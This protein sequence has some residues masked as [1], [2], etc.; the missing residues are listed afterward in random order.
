MSEDPERMPDL[1]PEGNATGDPW[2]TRGA[3][4]WQAAL[5]RLARPALL[6]ALGV[7]TM[8]LG[9]VIVGAV[10][11]IVPGA[12]VRMAGAMAALLRAYPGELYL[13]VGALFGGQVASSIVLR[14][15]R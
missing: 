6:W 9:V 1:H 4:E 15:R 3:P 10:E 8:G 12:G 11:A 7:V 5:I 14:K 2:E 13:L